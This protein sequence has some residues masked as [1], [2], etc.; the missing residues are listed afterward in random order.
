MI[1]LAFV[2]Q[3][4]GAGKSTIAANVA[5]YAASNGIKTVI[6]DLDQQASISAWHGARQDDLIHLIPSHPPLLERY[7]SQCDKEGYQLCVIDTPPHN[8]TAAANAIGVADLTIVPVRPSAFDLVAAQATFDLLGQSG[9][10]GGAVIN[11]VPSSTKVIDDAT[12]F[13]T[14]AGIKVIGKTGQR[15]AYQHATT[16]GQGVT[17]Y[18][19]SGRASAEIKELWATIEGMV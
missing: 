9:G 17:E 6:I 8:S 4:G 11:A 5:A 7:V 16:K 10:K 19:P 2:S 1:T 12:K 14:D 3:K 15:I 18:E 13:V